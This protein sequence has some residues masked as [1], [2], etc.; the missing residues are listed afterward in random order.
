[1]GNQKAGAFDPLP[2]LKGNSTGMAYWKK[3][4]WATRRGA[5][6]KC[7]GSVS[8]IT[9]N[10]LSRS[11]GSKIAFVNDA[12]Q[13][14]TTGA[15]KERLNQNYVHYPEPSTAKQPCCSLCCLVN[16]NRKVRSYTAVSHYDIFKGPSTQLLCKEFE[17]ACY[18]NRGSGQW[19]IQ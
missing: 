1:V 9:C 2:I 8:A 14:P 6:W 17:I 18:Q 16:L 15:L 13:D 10:L 12:E 5:K 4:Q 11:S 3:L 7:D 19:K